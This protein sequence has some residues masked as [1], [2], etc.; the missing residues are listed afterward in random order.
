MKKVSFF[1]FGIAVVC[2]MSLLASCNEKAKE[3]DSN[4]AAEERNDEKF[5]SSET[6]KDA[7]LVVKAVECNYAKVKLAKLAQERSSNEKLIAIAKEIEKEHQKSLGELKDLASKKV[8]SVPAEENDGAKDKLD[9]LRKVDSKDF[10][11][12]W[13]DELADKHKETINEYEE[14]L[15]NEKVDSDVKSWLTGTLPGLRSHLDKLIT[16]QNQLD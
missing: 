1:K 14:A 8:I 6:Q 4:K 2:S 10:N 15:K 13:V 5:Q 9:N 7:D 12:K 16:L 3:T 11:K